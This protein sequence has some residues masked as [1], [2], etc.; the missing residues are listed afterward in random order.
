VAAGCEWRHLFQESSRTKTA[1][2]G[3]ERFV[4]DPARDGW[5]DFTDGYRSD[6]FAATFALSKRCGGPGATHSLSLR[7]LQGLQDLLQSPGL[8]LRHRALELVWGFSL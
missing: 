8:E 1:S 5:H 4:P 2:F 3:G 7:W 6:E